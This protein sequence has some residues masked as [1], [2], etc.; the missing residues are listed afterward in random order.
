MNKLVKLT[1]NEDKEAIPKNEQKWC[2]VVD[3][4]GAETTLCTGEV[5]GLGEGDAE[6]ECKTT[7]RGGITC[8]DCMTRIKEIKSVR[9]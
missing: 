4:C 1:M 3:A 7:Q 9:L 2:L 6:G 5:Y 8:N